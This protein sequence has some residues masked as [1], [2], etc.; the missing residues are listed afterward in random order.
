MMKIWI[1][2]HK[3]ARWW[4]NIVFLFSED[5]AG[6][7]FLRKKDAAMELATFKHSEFLEVISATLEPSNQDNRKRRGII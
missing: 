6:K 4:G 5:Y 2:V 7:Y 3:G 1:I